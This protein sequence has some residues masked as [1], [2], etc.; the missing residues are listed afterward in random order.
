MNI[1]F[2]KILKKIVI[3]AFVLGFFIPMNAQRSI[4]INSSE[5]IN[6]REQAYDD[7]DFG[8]TF[9]MAD[10]CRLFDYNTQLADLRSNNVGDTLL[11]DFFEDK[12]YKSVIQRVAINCD[13]RT[14][15]TSKIVDSE[16]AYCYMV[17]SATT[18]T[19]SADLPFGDECFF[20]AIKKGQAYIA[21]FNRSELHKTALECSVA[22]IEHQEQKIQERKA[23]NEIRGFDDP[24]IIDV[25]VVYTPAAEVW[26]LADGGVTDI[27]DLI[28]IALQVSNTIMDNSETGVTFNM[29]YKHKTFYEETDTVEDLYRI[30]D[31]WDG[32]MDEVHVLRDQYYADEILFIPKVD[33]TGG[34]A[35]L[36]DDE[37]GFNPD[38]YAVAL[39]RVQQTSWTYT[40]VHEI[41]HNMGCHHHA[42]QNYQPGPGL[43]YYSSGW[44]GTTLQGN[45]F[46]TVMTYESGVYFDDGIDHKRVPYFSSPDIFFEGTPMGTPLADNVQTIKR[47]KTAIAAYRTAP[48][49]ILNVNPTT[50]NFNDVVVGKNSMPK[51]IT[52]S[53]TSLS[54]AISYEKEG[55]DAASFEIT[56]TSWNSTT[57]GMLSVIFSP[58]KAG[59]HDAV[60]T[61]SSTGAENKTVTL[62]GNGVGTTYVILASSGSN[63]TIDPSGS[64]TVTHGDDQSFVFTPDAN[65][66]IEDVIIDGISN[67]EAV[68]NGNYTFENVTDDHIISVTFSYVTNI[69][70]HDNAQIV[71]FPNPSTGELIVTSY[72]LQVTSIEVFDVYGRNVGI[73]FP[74]FGGVRGGNIS[75]LPS[76]VYFL[77]IKTV[78]GTFNRKI[79]KE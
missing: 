5:T 76:G 14:S 32:Y 4:N 66:E 59:M 10:R 30:T 69:A 22:M 54:G 44:R 35:W 43:F 18:I 34:V 46:S 6:L 39:S 42:D 19:I 23:E 11:L 16:F 27:H 29:V 72:E 25:L 48:T 57:G 28:D 37:N 55:A 51:T 67:S 74:S 63:G 36:L 1:L 60:V 56:E 33:F 12:Q 49:P 61:F 50:L 77:N 31:P 40:A 64:I 68:A 53:G 17:V 8:E 20:A 7:A 70:E 3:G 24:V 2:T 58:Q 26:A 45:K 38:Y 47:T 78:N 79:V 71:V 75:H 13:G 15:I 41:G 65:Y 52:V 21:Q 62:N 73:E 9:K